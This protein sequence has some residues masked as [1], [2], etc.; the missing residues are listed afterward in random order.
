MR[1]NQ[2][3]LKMKVTTSADK[4]DNSL[5]IITPKRESSQ[6]QFENTIA[7]TKLIKRSTV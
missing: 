4:F 5:K 6:K 7:S 1:I 2:Y 3:N